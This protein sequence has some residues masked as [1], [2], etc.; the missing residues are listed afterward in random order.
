MTRNRRSKR[1]VRSRMALTGQKYT[2][3]RRALVASGDDAGTADP[4]AGA[5]TTKPGDCVVWFTD[6]AHNVILLAEDEARMMSHPEVEPEHL[7]LAAARTGNAHRLLARQGVTA[8]P[9]HDAV[10][11]MNGFG[12]RLELRPHRSSASENVLRRA[13]AVAAARGVL[14]PSTQHLLLALAEQ[15]APARIL[16]QLGVSDIDALVDAAYPN[17]EPPVEEA[18][19]QRR[20][21]Q[22]AARVP[23]SPS[24]GP[25][26]PVFDRFTSQAKEAISAGI[27]Y[28]RLADAP[29]VEPAH[30]LFGVLNASAGVV[31]RI[32]AG[33]GWQIPRARAEEPRFSQATDI[34]TAAARRIVAE[35]VLVVA[36]RLDLRALTTGHLL[37]AL[38]ESPEE[39]T[40]EITSRLPDIREVTDAVIGELPG[41][42]GP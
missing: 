21:I 42:E 37:I 34:F 8:G 36:E 23:R 9:I 3:A 6:E 33:Y 26:P 5:A 10:L 17:R 28:A 25:I 41:G 20:A 4:D 35:D 19:L 13:I 40:D 14:G 30:L 7:L 38:L 11:E 12:E 15:E 39:G 16:A 2:D 1:A 18:V 32:R 27:D 29:Y 22:L 24:P 31:A